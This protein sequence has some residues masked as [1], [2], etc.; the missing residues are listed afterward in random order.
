MKTLR[1]H[2]QPCIEEQCI[3]LNIFIRKEEILLPGGR[4]RKMNRDGRG[5][6]RDDTGV[7]LPLPL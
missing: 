3:A 6:S 5:M 2:L 1:M 7:L 4:K